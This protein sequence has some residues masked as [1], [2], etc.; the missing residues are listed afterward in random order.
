MDQSIKVLRNNEL[1]FI[2][3]DQNAG[4]AGSVFVDFFGQKAATAVGPVI[5]ARRTGAP[6]LPMFIVRRDNDM[7]KIIVDAPIRMEEKENDEITIQH[8]ISRITK[9]IEKYVRQ[10]PHEWGWMHRRWKT[11]P[12]NQEEKG[13]PQL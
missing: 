13:A 12:Q 8:N 10:Y 3:L 7:H 4:S 5:F 1:L 11:R 2:P 6:I 9:V